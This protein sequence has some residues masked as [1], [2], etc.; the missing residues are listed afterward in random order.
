MKIL[1]LL[2]IILGFA[3]IYF[4]DIGYPGLRGGAVRALEQQSVRII[5]FLKSEGKSSK[6]VEAHIRSTAKEQADYSLYILG[7]YKIMGILLFSS[8]AINI[9]V[10]SLLLRKKRANET[11]L[12]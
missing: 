8:G 11:A 5:E 7:Q 4:S 12:D 2:L 6:E 10:G 3:S 9:G 1:G